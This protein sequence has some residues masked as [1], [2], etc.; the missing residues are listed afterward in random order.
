REAPPRGGGGP[1]APPL[2]D[3]P[4]GVLAERR[5]AVVVAAA[6]DHAGTPG[7]RLDGRGRLR[8]DADWFLARDVLAGRRGRFDELAVQGVRRGDIDDVDVV[9]SDQ[10]VPGEGSP[11]E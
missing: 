10:L 6:R 1:A 3:E 4:A 2:A 8:V 7:G 5:P 9:T 11:R